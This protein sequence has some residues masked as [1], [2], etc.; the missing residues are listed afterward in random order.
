[1]KTINKEQLKCALHGSLKLK[2]LE[3]HKKTPC[4]SQWEWIQRKMETTK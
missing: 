1:M 2:F 4:H 3:Q